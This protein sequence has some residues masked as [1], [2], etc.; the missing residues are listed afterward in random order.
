MILD[1]NAILSDAQAITVTAPST[2]L[3]D[4]GLMGVAAYNQVQLKRN[5]GKGGHIPLLIQ[6]VE[7]FATLTSLTFTVQTDDNAGFATPKD[8]LSEVVPVADLKKGYIS[9]IDKLPRG[10]VEQ[11]IRINYTVTGAAATAGKVTAGFVG[12]VDGAYVG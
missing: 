7:N 12:A 2:N 9:K 4:L 10:I 1:Q 5:L 3:Y 6:V 11:F 8:I